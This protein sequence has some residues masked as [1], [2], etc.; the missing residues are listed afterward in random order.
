[1]SYNSCEKLIKLFWDYVSDWSWEEWE[2][3]G[4]AEKEEIVTNALA[5]LGPYSDFDIDEAYDLFWEWAEGLTKDGFEYAL[6]E[7]VSKEL[8]EQVYSRC[9]KEDLTAEEKVD[10]WHNGT[11]RENYKAAGEAKLKTY[12]EIAK[13]KGYDEIVDII[14]GEFLRRGVATTSAKP[15]TSVMPEVVSEPVAVDTLKPETAASEP[16]ADFSDALIKDV[17]PAT[18]LSDKDLDALLGMA[19]QKFGT[20][21]LSAYSIWKSAGGFIGSYSLTWRNN[22]GN[23]VKPDRAVDKVMDLSYDHDKLILLVDYFRGGSH[24]IDRYYSIDVPSSTNYIV[25]RNTIYK[26]ARE[27]YSYYDSE[28]SWTFYTL[29]KNKTNQKKVKVFLLE[30]VPKLTPEQAEE[31]TIKFF[32]R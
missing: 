10:A 22:N 16:E 11:R 26:K 18:T 4:A 21:V 3:A 28:L 5:E 2:A 6:S 1:M 19:I 17:E 13:S 7:G 25:D 23:I 29:T 9:L 20:T 32:E 12:L 15:V 31:I 27:A 30:K 14:E 8:V 24:N